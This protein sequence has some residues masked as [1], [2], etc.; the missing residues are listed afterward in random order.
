MNKENFYI[1]SKAIFKGCRRPKRDPDYISYNEYG[2]VSSE[3]WYTTEGVYRDSRHWSSI[4]NISK[5]LQDYIKK[6]WPNPDYQ[7]ERFIL[8]HII[9]DESEKWP[10]FVCGKVSSCFWTLKYSKLTT[11][12]FCRWKNFKKNPSR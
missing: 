7:D 9:K 10:L 4:W 8:N 1:G 2:V 6:Y 3:Y 11:C 12:G 5:E